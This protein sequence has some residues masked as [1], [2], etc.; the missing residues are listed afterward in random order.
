[1]LKNRIFRCG[2]S[3]FYHNE[4]LSC[5]QTHTDEQLRQI[6]DVG[7]NGIWL[8]GQLRNL[9]P[10]KLFRGYVSSYEQRMKALAKL[11]QRAS[12][13]KLGLWLYF[14]EPLGLLKSH[15]FWKDHPELAG[16]ETRIFDGEPQ[17]ALC[18][19]TKAV[20][21]Y[22]YEG[23][24]SLLKQIPLAGLL[25]ITTSEQVS[26][27]WAH[28]L[29][30]P[31]TYN[32]A[33]DFWAADCRCPRCKPKGPV[34]VIVG[35]V[36]TIRGAVKSAR[37]NAQVV[38]WDWSWN[39]HTSPPYRKIVNKLPSDVILMGDF[40]RG[41]FVKRAGEKREVEEYSL[42][43][44]GPS[45]R[46]AGEV[47]SFIDNRPMFA[48]LQ[49]NTTH[50][51]ATVPSIPLV[52]S[53]YRKFA[54]LRK[55]GAAGVMTTWNFACHTDTLNVHA[56]NKLSRQKNLTDEKTWLKSLAKEYFGKG[57]DA[58]LVVRGWYAFQR[59]SSYYPVNGNKFVY[60][61]VVN[62][63]PAYPLKLKFENKPMGPAWEKH[64][65]GDRL[66]DSLGCFSLDEM[67]E[68]LKRLSGGWLNALEYYK[69]GL[70]SVKN[71]IRRQ[72]ELATA[73]VA[74]CCFR[75]TYNIY[76]WYQ[77]RKNKKTKSLDKIEQQ[78]I[79]D[80]IDNLQTALPYVKSDDSLGFHDEAKWRM[81]DKKTIENK[82][83]QLKCLI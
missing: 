56:V 49:I 68:L 59:A 17:L 29:S 2:K 11:C 42:V 48:K 73:T 51:L 27:C 44:P 23:F 32:S 18:P 53:L 66:E 39:M 28:V 30:S 31:A 24:H 34:E 35:I 75:S 40:E 13:Y 47:K 37:P 26:N 57:V 83:H 71:N 5:N 50:E 15:R 77:R 80:E 52:V 61:S 55:V 60:W 79:F 33:E 7:F 19:S 8:R 54:Y 41:G 10:S 14:T 25:L 4:I 20:Q 69:K 46:F 9:Q 70:A 62:Y 45:R 21:N 3:D 16:H 43:Y 81:F 67:V 12:K 78:I 36:K 63:A 64:E 72:K 38:A 22:L 1:M 74:G 76:Y 82:I 65:F 6:A 58:D